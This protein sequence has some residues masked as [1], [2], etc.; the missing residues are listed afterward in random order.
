[1]PASDVDIRRDESLLCGRLVALP[2]SITSTVT[3]S[4]RAA[5][6][7]ATA[8]GFQNVISIDFP[9]MPDTIELGRTAEYLVQGGQY[10]PDGMHQYKMTRPL[11]IP[12][13][14]KIHSFD[15]QY[16]KKGALT[17]LQLAARLH[18][19]VLPIST[20]NRGSS[21][22][23]LAQQVVKAPGKATDADQKAAASS[24]SVYQ[25][26]GN[27]GSSLGGMS[28]PVTCWLHLMWI[29]Q[30]QPGI[31]CVGYVRE[32]KVQ[33]NGPWLRGPSRSFNLPSSADFSFTFIHRP[34]HGNTPSFSAAPLDPNS[35]SLS[36]QAYADDVRERLF[37]TRS[38][39]Q[40]DSFQ[41]F[42][43]NPTNTTIPSP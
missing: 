12:I 43:N 36:T 5:F 15:Q 4:S 17:L 22:V 16:C 30:D 37:N 6:N 20:L 1:M 34:G 42:G 39:V 32:V 33:F 10:M 8:A 18:S 26:Q 2:S 25:L 13:S 40:A 19:F 21:T 7:S 27:G 38:L 41:G 23:P 35:L 31:S 14:F 9:A 3:G 11:E 24:D 28:A 29:G